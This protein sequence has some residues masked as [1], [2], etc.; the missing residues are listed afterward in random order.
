MPSR[1]S[2][3]DAQGARV[4]VASEHV[5]LDE[6]EA[7]SCKDDR[8]TPQYCAAA[9]DVSGHLMQAGHVPDHVL[10]DQRREGC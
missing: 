3:H 9:A 8:A 6:P 10:I 5:V 7:F 2:A 4:I 1:A